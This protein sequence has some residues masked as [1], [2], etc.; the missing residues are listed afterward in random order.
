MKKALEG[1]RVIDLTTFMSGPF[2]SMILGDLGAEIIKVEQPEEGDASR[3][4]PPYFHKGESLYYLSLNRNKR[5]LTL[6][7]ASDEG[8]EIF[9]G[10]VKKADIV[11]DNFR[12]GVL[13][14][15]GADYGRLREINPGIICCSISAFGPDGP[16]GS[17]PA[18]DLIIQALSGAMS[19]T[20]EEGRGPMR[21]G[22][23]MGDLAGSMW[24]VVG[25]LA[26]LYYRQKTGQGQ[27]VDISLL[28]SLVSLITYP[29][30]YY[31]Y[32][33]EV[34]KPLGSGHQAIV[35][36]QVFKTKD[37]YLAVA[38][39]R[40]KF[41]VLLCEAL[42]VPELM[43]DPRFLTIG[44]RLKNKEELYGI[45]NHLF[46]RKTNAEWEEILVKAGVPCAPVNTIDKVFVDPAIQHRG[47]VISIDHLGE[48]IQSFG[49]PI[50]MSETP[51]RE[52]HSAPRLGADN[53]EIL[54][55][56]LGYGPEEVE[57]LK[58]KKII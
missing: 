38:C 54:E 47:M 29:A 10:L 27:L 44:D 7:L 39:P 31:S 2:A 9:C 25:I 15:L 8:R 19:M 56:L 52:Y 41:W 6:N 18:Y 45:L 21:L 14:N 23:P 26:A 32:G 1:I 5:S 4:V 46:S 57:R 20:G 49:N 36:F 55:E 40:E 53:R 34:A 51:I 35:P 3:H 22:V 16:Y 43:S 12:P 24:A 17:R 42:K 48:E 13:T 37:Y 50:R 28:D 30:L 11:I 33:G 58:R